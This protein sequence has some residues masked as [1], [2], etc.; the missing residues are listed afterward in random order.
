MINS[1]EKHLEH[2]L[3]V[4]SSMTLKQENPVRFKVAVN[5]YRYYK[6][7]FKQKHKKSPKI[8]EDG[9]GA[10]EY[11][12]YIKHPYDGNVKY[13]LPKKRRQSDWHNIPWI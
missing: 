3:K 12:K 13:G 4:A 10:Q 6:S 11:W 8:T 7:K 9:Y 2:L 1:D 5:D